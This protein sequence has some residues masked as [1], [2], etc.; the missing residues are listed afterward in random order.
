MLSNCFLKHSQKTATGSDIGCR[1]DN[2]FGL[3]VPLSECKLRSV[4]RKHVSDRIDVRRVALIDLA[5]IHSSFTDSFFDFDVRIFYFTNDQRKTA[6]PNR[7][8]RDVA[9][10]LACRFINFGWKSCIPC[11]EPKPA[12]WQGSSR[13]LGTGRR[14]FVR[15]RSHYEVQKYRKSA[16]YAS[17]LVKDEQSCPELPELGTPYRK[18]S[19]WDKVLSCFSGDTRTGV[20]RIRPL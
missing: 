3:A 12:G 7:V 15:H 20:V 18:S 11:Y 6:Q 14:A 1:R 5:S 10:P 19:S 17:S 9:V 13:W 2:S 8:I 4:A 16:Q